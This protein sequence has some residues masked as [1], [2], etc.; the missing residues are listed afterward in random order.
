MQRA[1][2]ELFEGVEHRTVALREKTL[3]DVHAI[4]RIDAD[5]VGVER[6]M[7]DLGQRQAVGHDRLAQQFVPVGNDMRRIEQ[8]MLAQP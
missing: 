3:G 1:A 8:A 6:G 5:Q 2:L 4:V 7:V